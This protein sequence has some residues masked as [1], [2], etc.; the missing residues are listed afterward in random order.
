MRKIILKILSTECFSL[1]SL[2]RAVLAAQKSAATSAAEWAEMYELPRTAAYEALRS[3]DR[4][5]LGQYERGLLTWSDEFM[6]FAQFLKEEALDATG[7]A[8]AAAQAKA[9]SGE[10]GDEP[11]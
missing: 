10:E 5:G 11:G 2:Q 6:A 9:Q 3:V 8:D 1:R 4:V 7:G